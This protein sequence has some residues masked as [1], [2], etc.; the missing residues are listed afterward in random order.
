MP[1]GARLQARASMKT[2][3]LRS[4]ISCL[5]STWPSFLWLEHRFSWW[6]SCKTKH[7][8]PNLNVSHHASKSKRVYCCGDVSIHDCLCLW[9]G[10]VVATL[11]V[12]VGV[13]TVRLLAVYLGSW[14]GA[15]MGGTP[16]EHRRKVWQ[17]MI[18]QVWFVRRTTPGQHRILSDPAFLH[19]LQLL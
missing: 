2:W 9:Q 16:T 14:M 8:M 12:A 13:Y 10:R 7:G 11:W 1:A 3:A 6:V 5:W 15:W 4:R 18:T 19:H 17:G